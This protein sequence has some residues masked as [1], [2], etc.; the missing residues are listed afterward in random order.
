MKFRAMISWEAQSHD[1]HDKAMGRRVSNEDNF[2]FCFYG[3]AVSASEDFSRLINL[4]A[5]KTS[6]T[7]I[8]LSQSKI[9]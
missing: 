1:V 8:V 2:R 9:R 5:Q 3:P 6:P 4:F 7:T